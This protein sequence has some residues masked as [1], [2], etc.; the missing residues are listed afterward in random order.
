MPNSDPNNE[1]VSDQ[2]DDRTGHRSEMEHDH[3]PPGA[4]RTPADRFRQ[5][6][7]ATQS[8]PDDIDSEEDLWT[9]GYSFKAMIG[10]WI[11]IAIASV[12]L[13][14][15]P[16]FTELVSFPIA[17]IVIV[18]LWLVGSL[19]YAWRRLGVHYRLTTQRFVH[20]RGVLTRQSDRIEVIDI[21]DVRFTQGPIQRALGVGT[22]VLTS[23]DRTDPT[24]SMIGIAD[25]DAVAGL[26]D[27]TRRRERRR[28]SL[29]IEAI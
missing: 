23:S 26:I 10:T 2:R 7:A 19:R 12:G 22:I 20:Q 6:A 11:G 24:L 15:L 16:M 27:D 17:L 14:V 13:L 3:R 21:D 29:Q 4:E 25:V 28:H 18:M 1:T 8:G 9:G 5:Q